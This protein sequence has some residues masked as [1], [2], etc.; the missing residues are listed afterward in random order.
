M[1]DAVDDM[2]QQLASV[3]ISFFATRITNLFEQRGDCPIHL[4]HDTSLLQEDCLGRR[5]F[6][7]GLGNLRVVPMIDPRCQPCGRRS[8]D[9]QCN[10]CNGFGD[11]TRLASCKGR[12]SSCSR[13]SGGLGSPLRNT[14]GDG[15]VNVIT[16]ARD[17]ERTRVTLRVLWR[18]ETGGRSPNRR[19][20][21]CLPSDVMPSSTMISIWRYWILTPLSGG[22]RRGST[23]LVRALGEGRGD[24]TH[25][26]IHAPI[27]SP[28]GYGSGHVASMA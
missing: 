11:K 8:Y 13:E 3:A 28:Q 20:S 26:H 18:S 17:I 23:E 25:I 1:N 22:N 21:F 7:G 15:L 19:T 24:A 6:V 4:T 27:V 5:S 12:D 2:C 9:A 16:L 14:H 10:K